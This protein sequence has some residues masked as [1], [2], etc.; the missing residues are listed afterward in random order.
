MLESSSRAM[1]RVRTVEHAGVRADTQTQ[2]LYPVVTGPFVP[3]QL[4]RLSLCQTP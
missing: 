4:S 1:V 3:P 2:S